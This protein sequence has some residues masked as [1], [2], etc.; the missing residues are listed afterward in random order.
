VP[1]LGAKAVER[2]LAARRVRRLCSDDLKRLHVPLGKA[3]PFLVLPDHTPRPID[4]A[5][6]AA[7]LKPAPV[8]A[9]LFA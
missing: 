5:Q 3:L 6:V 1:G 2:V 9:A 7:R 4:D 8:Q